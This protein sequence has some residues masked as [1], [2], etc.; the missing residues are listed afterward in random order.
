M[1]EWSS[2]FKHAFFLKLTVFYDDC[3]GHINLTISPQNLQTGTPNPYDT[4]RIGGHVGCQ[5]P[6]TIKVSGGC[7][8][9]LFPDPVVINVLTEL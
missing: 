1:W 3:L 4:R 9:V 7:A 6:G 5:S 8:A 2:F